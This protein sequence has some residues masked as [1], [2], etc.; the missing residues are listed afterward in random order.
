MIQKF[1]IPVMPYRDPEI[2]AHLG[3]KFEDV[4]INVEYLPKNE[5]SLTNLSELVEEEKILSD[6]LTHE[7]SQPLQALCEKFEISSPRRFVTPQMVYDQVYSRPSYDSHPLSGKDDMNFNKYQ[8]LLHQT[9]DFLDQYFSRPECGTPL[10]YTGGEVLRRSVQRVADYYDITSTWVGFSPITNQSSI[11]SDESVTWD[12]FEKRK[13]S[14][15]TNDEI[16]RSKSLIQD[17]REKQPEIGGSLRTDHSTQS[18]PR[19]I[20]QKIQ[21]IIEEREAILPEAKDWI[22]R[23]VLR[24]FLSIY[25]KRKY[26]SISKSEEFIQ[27]NQYIFY[28]LQF[29]RESR[30][31]IRAPPFYNQAWLIEYIYRS[32]PFNYELAIK[33]HPQQ[34]GAQPR[35]SVNAISR[36]SWALNPNLN[37]HDVI[38]SASAVVT[39]NNTVGYEALMHGKPV[40][41][42]GDA[43][44]SGYGFTFDV[45]DL[46]DLPEV[47]TTATQSNGL[48]EK[49]VVE[50]SHGIIEGSVPGTWEKN[51][52]KGVS[53]LAE[54]IIEHVD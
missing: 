48:D 38:K 16:S 12:G 29:Y 10:Q 35:T 5:R 22:R 8:Q 6:Y 47:L 19:N 7:P 13:Y 23:N 52:P 37:A 53:K 39:L 27:E 14:D 26:H 21:R 18:I 44:Y 50:F 28:P 43:F 45:N 51:N 54:S 31:T 3:S 9:L 42:L 46:N 15:L 25:A 17:V 1:L 33:D 2:V 34:L 40:I 4:G 41:A 32:V 30:V 49:E 24:E 36:H 20:L 11:Y